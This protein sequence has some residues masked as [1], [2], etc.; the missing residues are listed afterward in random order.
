M[1]L[2][3]KSA[4]GFSFAPIYDKITQF[5]HAAKLGYVTAPKT[6]TLDMDDEFR[7]P[8]NCLIYHISD[9]DDGRCAI[10]EHVVFLAKKGLLSTTMD[11]PVIT[12]AKR[13]RLY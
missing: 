7:G 3:M 10:P 1:F 13:E 11:W 8:E 6:D 9:Y 5:I 4:G 2:L 12:R